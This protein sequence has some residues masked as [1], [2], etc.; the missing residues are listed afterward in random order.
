MFLNGWGSR[1][2]RMAD[3]GRKNI[4]VIPTLV[5][6]ERIL[7]AAKLA[8]LITI[9]AGPG[10]NVL[11]FHVVSGRGPVVAVLATETA[12][13]PT[14]GPSYFLNKF[15]QLPAIRVHEG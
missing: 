7:R 11:G 5:D 15:F 2:L 6:F 4:S 9:V 12:R 8:A 10:F 13:V 14:G 3:F 1:E